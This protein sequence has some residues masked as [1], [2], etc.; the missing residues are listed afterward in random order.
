MQISDI[1]IPFIIIWNFIV[2]FIYGLDK[3]RAKRHLWRI[4][5]KTLLICSFLLGGMGA[6]LAM[7]YFHHKTRHLKF[8][9]LVPLSF[10]L[11]TSFLAYSIL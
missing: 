4:P 10:L 7:K 2:F 3:Y 5:E 1:T 6:F 8:Q 11:T 9:I